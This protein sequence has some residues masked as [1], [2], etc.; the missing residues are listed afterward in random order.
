MLQWSQTIRG[1]DSQVAGLN[2]LGTQMNVV[3]AQN[4]ELMSFM[5]R[6]SQVR[7]RAR[8]D[9]QVAA[10]EEADR[11]VKINEAARAI[12]RKSQQDLQDS[13]RAPRR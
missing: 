10:Q 1:I 6:D 13:L 12:Y 8:I 9:A 5:V 4:A 2:L 7:Q 11:D 3:V